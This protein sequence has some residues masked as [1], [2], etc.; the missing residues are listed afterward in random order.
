MP[1]TDS[2]S[3]RSSPPVR[4]PTLLTRLTEVRPIV[5]MSNVI[6]AGLLRVFGPGISF[7]AKE[8]GLGEDLK[9]KDMQA[10][11]YPIWRCDV[12]IEGKVVNEYSREKVDTKGTVAIEGGYVPGQSPLPSSF[13]ITEECIGNSFAPLSYISYAT[14]PIPDDLLVFEPGKELSQLGEGYEVIPIPF[15]VSPLG[16]L[17]KVR[18]IVGSR[19]DWRGL[20]LDEPKWQE[21][22]VR[23]CPT[24]RYD[25]EVGG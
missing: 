9:L 8:F 4:P 15:T 7:L 18:S 13:T 3:Q 21:V 2:T 23:R 10:A 1:F 5:N 11:L 25:A 14:Q 16:L 12:L 17:K 20:L 19:R 22:M 24:S 6:F